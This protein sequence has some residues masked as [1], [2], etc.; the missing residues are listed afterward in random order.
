MGRELADAS[1]LQFLD[2]NLMNAKPDVDVVCSLDLLTG[3]GEPASR[4]ASYRCINQ[5]DEVAAAHS[6]CPGPP[7]SDRLYCGLARGEIRLFNLSRPGTQS[8]VTW[9]QLS[10]QGRAQ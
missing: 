6:L 2:S 8:Q 1:H 7:G 9:L 4:I 10:G 5:V 3:S